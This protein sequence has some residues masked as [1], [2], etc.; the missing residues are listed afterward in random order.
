MVECAQVLRFPEI[1]RP[2][3][4]NKE[5]IAAGKVDSVGPQASTT[6]HI[7]AMVS[8]MVPTMLLEWLCQA[9]ADGGAGDDEDWFDDFF[10]T[11]KVAADAHRAKANQE[12]DRH[13][14][15]STPAH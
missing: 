2:C 14:Q 1:W 15:A 8:I 13:V 12:A 11:A 3:R 10:D 4:E 6:V 9:G 7:P 5:P